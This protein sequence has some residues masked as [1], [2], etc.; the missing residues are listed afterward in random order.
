MI[1]G[2]VWFL[3]GA[4]G[5]TPEH[6]YRSRAA[7][8]FR[9]RP[10]PFSRSSTCSPARSPKPIRSSSRPPSSRPRAADQSVR[11]EPDVP[12]HLQGS[13]RAQRNDLLRKVSEVRSRPTRRPRRKP[14]Q[15]FTGLIGPCRDSGYYLMVRPLSAGEH[16]IEFTGSLSLPDSP[17]GIHV[18]YHITVSG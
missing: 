17:L 6:P 8:P 14:P 1:G 2:K 15:P 13:E 10:H 7:A 12:P 11:P 4:T 9:R 5:G 3:A 18:T 16:T